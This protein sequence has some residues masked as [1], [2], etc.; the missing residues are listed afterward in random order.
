MAKRPVDQRLALETFPSH[1]LA[2]AETRSAHE[3]TLRIQAGRGWLNLDLKAVWEFREL[4]YFLVWR[5]VK[6]RYK[7]TIM[8]ALWAILQPVLTTL[9]FLAIG[10]YA[11]LAS[12]E[13][14]Y[15]VFIFTALL[16]MTYFSQAIIRSGGSLVNDSNLVRKVYFPR[17]IIPFA[18]VAAP[19]VDLFVSFGVLAAM[20]AWFRHPLRWPVL[21]LPFF[22]LLAVATALGVGVWLSALNARY[23][24]VGHVI[25]FLT[26][27]WFF[28]SPVFY[29]PTI[30]PEKWR[31]LYSLNPM[32]GVIEGFRWAL[33]GH[34]V[35]DFVPIAITVVAVAVLLFTGIVFF[36]RMERILADVL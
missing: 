35:P 24:D 25:P 16:P 12:N 21:T 5:D 30:F 14:P 19:L 31:L 28:A 18:A 22:L 15:A 26:Q 29:A 27:L 8:G 9:I 7:Q 4:L 3:P 11:N 36:K 13:S 6:V 33:L 23:R 34:K 1:A 20:L 17:L 32:V 2:T 10:T